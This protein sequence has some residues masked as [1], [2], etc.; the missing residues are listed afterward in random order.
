MQHQAIAAAHAGQV[1]KR[2][3]ATTAP[4][5]PPVAPLA[6]EDVGREEARKVGPIVGGERG[7]EGCVVGNL[8][9]VS[10]FVSLWLYVCNLACRDGIIYYP[11]AAP[12][13]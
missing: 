13:V 8:V 7:G 11:P 9:C 2:P 6:I 4:L 3:N 5:P 10:V 1:D 12:N